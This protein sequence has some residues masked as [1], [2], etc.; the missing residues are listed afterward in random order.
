MN[1]FDKFL[2]SRGGEYKRPLLELE[3][4]IGALDCSQD[5]RGRACRRRGCPGPR[6]TWCSARGTWTRRARFSFKWLSKA[7]VPHVGT[8]D[9]L[10]TGEQASRARGAAGRGHRA[11]GDAEPGFG[12]LIPPQVRLHLRAGGHLDL[13]ILHSPDGADPAARR[14]TPRSMTSSPSCPVPLR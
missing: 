10:L 7:G 11:G 6:L 12:C 4:V 8:A 13:G 2:G 1:P 9:K 3:G 14:T 5:A